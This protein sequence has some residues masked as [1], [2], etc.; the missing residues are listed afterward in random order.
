MFPIDCHK[1]VREVRMTRSEID[2]P[3]IA[4]L[5]SVR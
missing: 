1:Y 4:A 5:R 3:G 2:L